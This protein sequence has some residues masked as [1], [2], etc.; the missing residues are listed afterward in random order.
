M[1]CF[2]DWIYI[3]YLISISAQLYNKD[4]F[5]VLHAIVALFL[6]VKQK[7]CAINEL[8]MQWSSTGVLRVQ[9]Y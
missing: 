4:N 8:C 7:L 5:T 6:S 3:V 1:R 2:V 9:E